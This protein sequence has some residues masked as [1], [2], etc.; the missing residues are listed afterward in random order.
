LSLDAKIANAAARRG[1]APPPE[2][3]PI[4]FSKVQ[5]LCGNF[6]D[7]TCRAR[8]GL[9]CDAGLCPVLLGD[10]APVATRVTIDPIDRRALVLGASAA[11]L[12][13]ATTIAAAAATGEIVK[14]IG[15]D[16]ASASTSTNLNGPTTTTPGATGGA[17]GGSSTSQGTLLGPAKDVSVGNPATFTVPSSGDPGIVLELATSDYVA[18]DTVCPHMGCV[19]GFSP[20]ANLLVCPCHGSQFQ[21][22]NG[23]VLGGPAPHGLTKLDVVAGPDGNLYL[24]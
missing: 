1:G 8:A 19:V 4:A 16:K 24:K 18:Y 2:L 14:L 23:D 6:S 21:V 9:A 3:V 7:N 20:S 17:S 13:G 15:G 10:H 11:A 12:I 5:E 22:T